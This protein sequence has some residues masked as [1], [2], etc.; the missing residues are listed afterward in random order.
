MESVTKEE[1]WNHMRK[2]KLTPKKTKVDKIEKFLL[3]KFNLNSFE[4]ED[5]AYKK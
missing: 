5:K 2:N 3:E 1:I 4:I